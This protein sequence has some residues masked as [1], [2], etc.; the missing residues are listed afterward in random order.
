M[1]LWVNH[2]TPKPPMGEEIWGRREKNEMEQNENRKVKLRTGGFGT[3]GWLSGLLL[4]PL[5]PPSDLLLP[6]PAEERLLLRLI[7]FGQ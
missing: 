1:F 6:H 7:E 5:G 3:A 4:V 2:Y